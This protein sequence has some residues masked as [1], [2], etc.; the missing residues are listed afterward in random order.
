MGLQRAPD[1]AV[2]IGTET[3]SFDLFS[4]FLRRGTEGSNPSP[5]SGESRANSTPRRHPDLAD[6]HDVERG[7][8][9]HG[10]LKTDR[11]AAARHGEYNWFLLPQLLTPSSTGCRAIICAARRSMSMSANSNGRRWRSCGR[12][13][14]C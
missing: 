3:A 9:S 14:G 2:A 12:I 5:S 8:E 7:V 6:Q 1:G 11:H 4:L 10:D 13:A